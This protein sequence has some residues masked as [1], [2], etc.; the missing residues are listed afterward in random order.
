MKILD[1]PL[2]FI[3]SWEIRSHHDRDIMF[4][5]LFSGLTFFKTCW[6]DPDFSHCWSPS[7]ISIAKRLRPQTIRYWRPFVTSAPLSW[8]QV[9]AEPL[10]MRTDV[11]YFRVMRRLYRREWNWLCVNQ[12][13]MTTDKGSRRMTSYSNSVWRQRKSKHNY[14]HPCHV[15]KC[16]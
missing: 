8:M 14:H 12:Q 6:N 13:T 5:M 7:A 2:Y 1:P 16:T 4:K 11:V 10:R 15:I 3:F 9:H